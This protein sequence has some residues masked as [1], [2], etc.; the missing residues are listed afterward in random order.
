MEKRKT[1]TEIKVDVITRTDVRRM[2]NT[3]ELTQEE[4]RF[5]RMRYGISEGPTAPIVRRGQDNAET[6][7][8]LAMIEASMI[9]DE[10]A[11]VNE[12]VKNRIIS[13][14]RGQ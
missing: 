4:E 9:P 2:I 1:S 14:L 7:A 13:R 3:T 5:V 10:L 12:S 11:Q 8:K 6:R